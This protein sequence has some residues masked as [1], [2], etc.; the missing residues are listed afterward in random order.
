VD[1]REALHVTGEQVA[2][3]GIPR[4]RLARA[5]PSGRAPAWTLALALGSGAAIAAAAAT[6]VATFALP[7]ER[8]ISA[9]GSA[10]FEKTV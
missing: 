7:S 9:S 4:N 5:R 10:L 2:A 6:T 1:L 8:R 3:A